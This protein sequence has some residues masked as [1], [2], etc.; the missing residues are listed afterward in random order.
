MA[1]LPAFAWPGG[2]RRLAQRILAKIPKH[3]CYV[4]PFAG[5]LGVLLSKPPSPSEI[6]NDLD[7]DLVRFY[8]CVRYHRDELLRELEFVLNSREEF[9]AAAAQP[10]LTDIQRA[11]RWFLRISLSWGGK[12]GTFGYA[13]TASGA[14]ANG[15]RRSRLS[16]IISLSERLDKVAIEHLDWRDVLRRYDSVGTCFYCDPPYTVGL[17]YASQ[18][19]T[20]EDHVALRD[21]LLGVRGTWVLSYDE[22]PLVRQLYEGY[23][24][25]SF[26]RPTGLG[27]AAGRIGRRYREVLI[28]PASKTV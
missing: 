11:A 23:E 24:I 14:A 18:A 22:S 6:V 1:T 27:N 28:T 3:V 25:E 17:Q 20:V 7:G 16:R 8:R 26:D 5:G 13:R 12:G 4:E 21:A 10:G 15:S 2:K 9:E 19:W